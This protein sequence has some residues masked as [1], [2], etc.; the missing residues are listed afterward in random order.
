MRRRD[1][2]VLQQIGGESL[3]VPVGAR[4]MDVNG[5][6]T[7]NGT[8]AFLWRL[9]GEPRSSDELASA[10]SEAYDVDLSTARQDVR[11]FLESISAMGL[12]QA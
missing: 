7:L 9:L 4:V 6:V 3:L 8:A 2:F 11:A 1:G 10:V 5:L 12:L